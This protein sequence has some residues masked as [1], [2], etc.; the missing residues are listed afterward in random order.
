[1]SVVSVT[2]MRYA[3]NA[4]IKDQG[5]Q[6]EESIDKS[7]MLIMQILKIGLYILVIN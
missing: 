3:Y 7:K 6:K 4:N 5:S 2:N 1:M